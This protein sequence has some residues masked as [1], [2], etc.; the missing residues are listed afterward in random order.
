MFTV[1]EGVNTGKEGWQMTKR[2]TRRR[3]GTRLERMGREFKESKSW[4]RRGWNWG[5]GVESGG[6]GAG[7]GK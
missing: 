6:E 5:E 3:R 7:T 2:R 1:R 4:V